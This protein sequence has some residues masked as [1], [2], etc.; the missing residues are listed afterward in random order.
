MKIWR[1]I[2]TD[3]YVWTPRWEGSRRPGFV[4]VSVCITQVLYIWHFFVG[5]ASGGVCGFWEIYKDLSIN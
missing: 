5:N 4:C 2:D 1:H 3:M